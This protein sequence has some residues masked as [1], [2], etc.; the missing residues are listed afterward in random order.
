MYAPWARSSAEAGAWVFSGGTPHA[1]ST[2][3]VVDPRPEE[4]PIT[5]GPYVESKEHIGG[6]TIIRAANLDAVL[7]WG[8]SSPGRRRCR[9][10]CARSKA[11]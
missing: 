6:V 8:E 1:P 5:D 11:R 7:E 9:S 4:M 10:R 2:A 3:T